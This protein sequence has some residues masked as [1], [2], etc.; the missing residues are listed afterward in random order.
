[1]RHLLVSSNAADSVE[2]DSAFLLYSVLDF[3]FS[4]ASTTITVTLP[5]TT[6]TPPLVAPHP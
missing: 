3:V 5:L 6:T 2:S 4:S 1:M